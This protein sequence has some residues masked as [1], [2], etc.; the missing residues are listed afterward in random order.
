MTAL[1]E[2]DGELGLDSLG[3][4]LWDP[5]ERGGV[6]MGS[7]RLSISGPLP[8]MPLALS[9]PASFSHLPP[10]LGS[11]PSPRVCPT[12]SP[13]PPLTGPARPGGVGR[14]C[15]PCRLFGIV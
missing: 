7:P 2:W 4:L 15:Q 3:L 13:P 6:T 5:K 11:P 1:G 14:L 10:L 9:S 8:P 12:P